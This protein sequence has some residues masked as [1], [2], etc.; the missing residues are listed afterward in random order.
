MLSALELAGFKSFAD[1][2]RFDFPEGITVIVGPNGSGKSNVVDAIKWVLGAQ[3]AKALRGKDMIDVIFKG[4]SSSG[5]KP[6]N[7]AEATLVFDNS[8][9]QLPMDTEE[10]QVTRRVYRSGEGEYLINGQ[11]CRLKDIKDL[12]RGTGVGVDAYSLIEQGKVDRMLQA[13]PRDRRVI[14][15]EAAGISRFNAKKAEAARRLVRVDQNMVRLKDIVD[16]VHTR[17]RSLQN[18]A[19]K[20]QRYREMTSRLNEIRLQLGWTEYSNLREKFES[21]SAKTEQLVL[22]IEAYQNDLEAARDGAQQA[23]MELHAVAQR[24]QEV[25]GRLQSTLQRIAVS[26]NQQQTLH[27]RIEENVEEQSRQASKL[28]VLRSR[29]TALQSELQVLSVEAQ[30]AQSQFEQA[31]SRAQ[32]AEAHATHLRQELAARTERQD[33]L[34]VQHV[35]LL[36]EVSDK[37][38]EAAQH[39]NLLGEL[40]QAISATELQI[41]ENQAAEQAARKT[42]E[43]AAYRLKTI[44]E[45]NSSASEELAAAQADLKENELRLSS[46]QEQAAVLQG[47]LEG[48]SERLSILEQLQQHLEGV[49]AGARHVLDLVTKSDD[50]AFQTVRGLVADLIEVDV[51]LAPLIDTGLGNSANSLVL[52]DGQ[53]FQTIRDGNLQVPGRLSLMRLDRL[54]SRRY[55]EKIQLDGVQGVLG[56]ADRLVKCKRDVLPLIRYLLGT[57]WLVENLDVAL[58]LGH[59]RG[60]GLRFV[61]ASC[62][63]I[64]SDG[65]LTIGALQSTTGLVSRRSEIQNAKDEIVECRAQYQQAQGEIERAHGRILKLAPTVKAMET[66]ARDLSQEFARQQASAQNAVGKL[67]DLES[68]ASKLSRTLTEFQAKRAA[69]EPTINELLQNVDTAQQQI[70]EIEQELAGHQDAVRLH[71]EALATATEELTTARIELARSEQKFAS[72][73]S[74]FE[75]TARNQRERAQ[76]VQEA[77][78]ELARLRQKQLDSELSILELTS[79]LAHDYLRSETE[80]SELDGLATEAASQR[81]RRSAAAKKLDNVTRTIDKLSTQLQ[82]SR[83]DAERCSESSE[84]LLKRYEEDYQIDFETLSSAEL[85]EDKSEHQAMD[86]E[87]SRLRQDI[88]SVGE[89]NMAALAELDELQSR[90]DYLHGQYQDLTAAKESLQ[91]IIQKINTDSRKMFMETLEIIR[92]NFQKLYRKSFGGGNADIVLEAGEDVLECGI[93]IIAT[94]PGK[95]ALSNSLLSG[96]EKALTAVALLL[97]IFQ[98]RPSPFCVL[99]EVDAPFDEANIGRFVSVLTEFLDWTKFIIVTHSKK[100]MTA[101]TTL[102]GVTMQESGVSKQVAVRFEDVNEKGEIIKDKQG[103]RRA[104]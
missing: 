21:A 13:S 88:S 73:N 70:Q 90:Y 52:T 103:N 9:H 104:A 49:D 68:L 17:L 54:P 43:H 34:R 72:S 48:A 89:I 78:S 8:K 20:A 23:E 65:T 36:R 31:K 45:Q 15:E 26:Q 85:I 38:A 12:F 6:S 99:D 55:G 50:P 92:V 53:L 32:A 102:Y 80:D 71:G 16:E 7:S 58:S 81:S 75:Q 86:T 46:L 56:R 25:E 82:T 47:R 100:T 61:T 18:Q 69:V 87:A 27:Q 35:N 19:T 11:P 24:C 33:A 29:A 44:H 39:K 10:V 28:T 22:E 37:T 57:T 64:E 62:E 83:T 41:A 91:R 42:A 3:S 2:T 93:D 84:Q 14:F 30:T 59:F 40:S 96:G 76:A 4:S 5:R 97:A 1:K 94:P 66:K 74:V 95:T 79:Q 60:A 63:L 51:N 67:D 98:Y 77:V 101:S